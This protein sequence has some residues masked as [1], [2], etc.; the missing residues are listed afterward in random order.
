M[1]PGKLIGISAVVITLICL[2]FFLKFHNEKTFSAARQLMLISF[3]KELFNDA[4]LSADSRT[5]CASCHQPDHDYTDGKSVA[6][7]VFGRIGTRNTPSLAGI[8]VD[9]DSPL[10]W[11]GRR[12]S[13]QQAVLDPLTNPFEMGMPNQEEVLHRVMQSAKYREEFKQL[14]Q[15]RN[16]TPNINDIALALTAYIRSLNE[17]NSAYDR[18]AYGD[19]SA[20]SG[21]AQS[22]LAIFKG[23][24]QCAECHRLNGSPAALTDHDFHRSGVGMDDVLQKLP[25]LTTEVIERSLQGA[26]IGNRVAA[27]ADEAALGRFNVTKDPT[28]IGLF[29]TPS[30]RNV[31]HTAPYMHDG[32]INTLDDAIDREAYYR[33]LQAGRPLNLSIEDRRALKAF[34]LT[35]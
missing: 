14:S 8:G 15:G 7:G 32:S 20:L 2:G 18:Y 33:G 25:E 11:D 27:H 19:K 12:S 35:L 3:G 6:I 34:L 13:L 16:I 26:D 29:R 5:R 21:L 4:T 24:G 22:G 17:Q 31:S 28:D 10:F 9:T 23:K 30:L 1:R